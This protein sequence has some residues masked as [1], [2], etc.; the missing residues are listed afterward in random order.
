[1]NVGFFFGGHIEVEDVGDGVNVD[2]TGGNI[3]G[4]EYGRCGA[5][6]L[7]EDSDA[8]VLAFVGM[9]GGGRESGFCELSDDA[10]GAVFRAAEDDGTGGCEGIEE[11]DEGVSFLFLRDDGDGLSNE[12]SGFLAGFDGDADGIREH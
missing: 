6:E 7:F 1:M 8:F 10:I 11:V 4:D 2:A 3:G 9:N 5:A 12:F